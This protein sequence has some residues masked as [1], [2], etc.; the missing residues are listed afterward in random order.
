MGGDGSD[1]VWDKSL[2]L[3]NFRRGQILLSLRSPLDVLDPGVSHRK[4]E[5]VN[6]ICGVDT[7]EGD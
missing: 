7:Y 4:L 2:P 1:F 5:A 3:A 6:K